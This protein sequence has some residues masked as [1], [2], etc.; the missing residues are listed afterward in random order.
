MPIIGTAGHVDHGKSTLVTALTG[1]DP[2][3]WA[4]EKERGLTIDLGF[5]WADLGEGHEVGFVDVPGHE[6]F[7]KNM[8]AGVG[9]VDVGLLVVAADEGWMPQTE[10]HMAVLD[11]L[12]VASGVIAITRIDLV[13]ADGVELVHLEVADQVAGTVLEAWP[14]VAVSAV[15][16]AGMDQLRGALRDQLAVVAV[17]DL[18]RPRLW[19]DRSFVIAGAGVVVTGTLVDG[20]LTR[21]TPMLLY[22]SRREVRIRGLQSHEQTTET[23]HPGSRTAVNLTGIDRNDAKRGTMLGRPGGFIVTSRVL[24][25]VAAVR[26]LAEPL[27]DRGAYHF[28]LGTASVPAR[29]RF[30]DEGTALLRLWG[31]VATTMGDRFILRETGRRA[32]VGGGRILDPGPSGRPAAADIALLRSAVDGDADARAT[33]LLRVH[34]V[35]PAWHVAAASAGG[36]AEG[37]AAGGLLLTVDRAVRYLEGAVTGTRR[38]QAANPMRPGIPKQ[39]LASEI[40]VDAETLDALLATTTELVEAG[41]FIHTPDFASVVEDPAWEPARE[42]LSASLAVPRASQI[43]LDMESLHARIRSGD[44]VRVGD[45]LVYLPEQIAAVLTSLDDVAQPFTVGDF[46]DRL[47]LT[48]R[49]AVPLLEWLDAQ[50][51]TRRDGDVR[52]VRRRPSG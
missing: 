24:A 39:T 22:P 10:E 2:D 31:E 14:I 5:A 50:G 7:I 36:T 35:L 32:V 30:L 6:R 18:A 1:R 25:T 47:G 16:G 41:A 13:D 9:G 3:R 17:P 45:D 40:G 21:D 51:W 49:Q 26:S 29:V 33:A 42:T 12:D 37:L 34:G 4:E 11:L 27:T 20:V 52:T 43:G 19:I 48:R 44:L 38:F 28:H 23:A 8:L 15:S 46:R